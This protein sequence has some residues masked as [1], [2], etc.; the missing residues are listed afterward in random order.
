MKWHCANFLLPYIRFQTHTQAHATEPL[1]LYIQTQIISLD[2]LYNESLIMISFHQTHNLLNNFLKFDHPIIILLLFGH[3]S[4]HHYIIIWT[5]FYLFY[6]HLF[7]I[8]DLVSRNCNIVSDK[9]VLC[10]IQYCA[11]PLVRPLT[12][13]M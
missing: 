8:C 3:N 2:V 6:D 9:V 10:C 11:L 13:A 5:S 12:L 7:P 1:I 4:I